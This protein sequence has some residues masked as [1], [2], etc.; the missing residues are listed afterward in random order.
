MIAG[1]NFHV[2]SVYRRIGGLESIPSKIHTSQRV[3]RRIGGLENVFEK[4][5]VVLL[6]YRR[7]GGLEIQGIL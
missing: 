3:Y 6:V 4:V 7:I 1:Y 2:D 5:L